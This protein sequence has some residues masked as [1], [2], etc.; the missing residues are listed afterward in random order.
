MKKKMTSLLALFCMMFCAGASAQSAYQ[1]A[2]DK[3]KSKS[4][5]N[6]LS[7]SLEKDKEW[8]RKAAYKY[9]E[10]IPKEVLKMAK[11]D[12]AILHGTWIQGQTKSWDLFGKP[13]P[14]PEAYVP[15]CR[16]NDSV[17]AIRNMMMETQPIQLY[18]VNRGVINV[19][20]YSLD[21]IVYQPFLNSA[22]SNIKESFGY[23][24]VLASLDDK[25]FFSVIDI[26]A[27][28]LYG[29]VEALLLHE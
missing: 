29:S 7:F 17:F 11:K 9:R 14:I 18:N 21:G 5:V 6:A 23:S 22:L 4:L 15:L 10:D 25:Y 8:L 2:Y 28:R 16:Y 1:K 27:C 26:N 3:A 12:N 19:L 13:L 20:A 24:N